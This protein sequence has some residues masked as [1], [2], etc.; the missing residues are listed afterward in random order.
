MPAQ[1][2][3]QEVNFLTFNGKLFMS[4]KSA[5]NRLH[6][7]DGTTFRR[8]GFDLPA[9][10]V[11]I[12][13]A[14]GAVTDTRKYRISWTKQVS[15]VT[16]M[17]SNLSVASASQ[18]LAAQQATVTRTAAPGEGETH[19]EL[20]AASTPTFSDYRLQAT[21]VIATTTAVDNAALGNCSP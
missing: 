20:W 21:T 12:V 7:W 18:A 3:P 4:F 14:G 16:V 8:C 15:G 13:V 6:V 2:T 19:W 10:I 1:P 17:R 9:Q 11:T 5:H